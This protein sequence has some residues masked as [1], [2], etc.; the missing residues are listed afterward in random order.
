MAIV[1]GM[2]VPAVMAL[3]GGKRGERH[4]GVGK[5]GEGGKQCPLMKQE[6]SREEGEGRLRGV[7]QNDCHRGAEYPQLQHSTAHEST[8]E[9][10]KDRANQ[11]RRC[12]REF[13]CLAAGGRRWIAYSGKT[14][15]PSCLP[16]I[17]SL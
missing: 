10:T 11:T 15:E 13:E 9:N 2:D 3:S 4:W 7:R 1:K 16:P 8:Q 17:N 14:E 6:G 12:R 5:V